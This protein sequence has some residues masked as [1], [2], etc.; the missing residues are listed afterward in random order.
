MAQAV[1]R[2]SFTA[3]ARVRSLA[4]AGEMVVDK[5]VL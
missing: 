4:R 3:H 2:Q 1:S 5:V